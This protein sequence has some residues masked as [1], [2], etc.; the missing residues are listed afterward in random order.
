MQSELLQVKFPEKFF[1]LTSGINTVLEGDL[2]LRFSKKQTFH[3]E[4]KWFR[5]T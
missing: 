5:F 3:L 1:N 4:G 2:G